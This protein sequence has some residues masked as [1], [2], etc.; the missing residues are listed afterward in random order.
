[1][2]YFVWGV[3]QY[4]IADG[5]EGKKKGKNVI[6]YGIIGLA[7]IVSVWGLVNILTST[8]HLD[9]QVPSVSSLTPS[10]VAG[11]QS[12]CNGLTSTS[13]FQDYLNYFSTCIINNSI[14]PL[15]FAVAVVML[16]WGM[17]KFFIINSD[18]EA[19]RAQGKQYMIWGII[20]LAVMLSVWGLVG[21]LQSTFNL[22][23]GSSVLP[24]IQPS[25]SGS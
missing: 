7:V 4:I 1:M 9:G 19:K 13:K 5:E 25:T 3:V 22:K 18:E 8:F 14:I 21:I 11:N 23:T 15:I 24:Q 6:V 20:A 17:V 16:I 2:V 10:Q 12:A